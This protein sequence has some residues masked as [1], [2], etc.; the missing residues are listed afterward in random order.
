VPTV[1]L[2]SDIANTRRIAYVGLDNRS[3]GRTAGYLIARFIRSVPAQVAMIAGSLSYRG[4]EER[5]MGFLHVMRELFPE[6]AVVGLREG[7]DDAATNYRLVRGLLEQHADLLGLYNIG[8]ASDG[9]GR[10]LKEAGRE[11]DVVFVG[12]GLTS[13]TR[14]MLI[15]G[16]MD[17]VITQ[18]P[19]TTVMNCVRVFANLR[20]G[21]DV[22][23]GVEPVRISIV[24]RDNLP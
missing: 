1:T 23:T 18:Y 16:T 4:H 22:M 8:G 12:H 2:I 21:R 5:E 17:A 24:L 13:D 15:D 7:R 10:A 20:D 14:V 11:H 19:H 6:L 9:V 3:A